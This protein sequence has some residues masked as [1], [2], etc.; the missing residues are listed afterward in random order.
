MKSS[1]PQVIRSL[2]RPPSLLL[3]LFLWRSQSGQQPRQ[4]ARPRL[5]SFAQKAVAISHSLAAL[6]LF[7]CFAF[8]F[9][10]FLDRL[11]SVCGERRQT[12]GLHPERAGIGSA[13]LRHS[14]LGG[15]RQAVIS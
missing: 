2:A 15:Q 13:L 10:I 5:A 8:Y 11:A 12:I 4:L 3:S 9:F 1:L 14:P 6:S 7:F